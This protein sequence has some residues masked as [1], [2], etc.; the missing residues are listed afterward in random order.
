MRFCSKCSD[1]K[2][3]LDFTK[4]KSTKNGLSHWCKQCRS[5]SKKARYNKMM[6][7]GTW[8]GSNPAARVKALTN[9]GS[10]CK[11]CGFSNP[12]ALQIDHINGGG[13]T[14]L[15]STSNPSAVYRK[16]ANGEVNGYQLLCVNCNW[17]KRWENQEHDI[18]QGLNCRQPWR[19]R[20]RLQAIDILGGKCSDCSFN[21]IRALQI[22]H[23]QGNGAMERQTLN[24]DSL[25]S[26][27]LRYDIEEYQL[28]C[29][30]CN[31]IKRS[32]NLH[33]KGGRPNEF[34]A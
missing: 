6:A 4:D 13:A 32:L 24:R 8:V 21:D 29:A 20:R 1:N 26:K 34:N 16:I 22:D 17:I 27:I 5:I 12:A 3:L 31:W 18:F 15:K 19:K 33:E 28:L 10:I 14:E 23:V 30:N 25:I 11:F 7:N 9:L 2:P